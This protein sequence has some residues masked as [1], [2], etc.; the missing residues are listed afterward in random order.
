MIT[1]DEMR[2]DYNWRHAFYEAQFSTYGPDIDWRSGH[3]KAPE[4]FALNHVVEVIHAVE[5]ENDGPA[6]IAVCRMDDGRFCVMEAGCDYTGW[7]CQA[8]GSIAWY[9]TIADA[10]GP[11]ALNDDQRRRLGLASAPPATIQ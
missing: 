7:D 3:E 2:K 1:V 5:G 8:G 10:T 4:E 9:P 11:L 6:W